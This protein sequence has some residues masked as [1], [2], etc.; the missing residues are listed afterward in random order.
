MKTNDK[1]LEGLK[2][3][4]LQAIEEGKKKKFKESD[5]NR[6]NKGRFAPTNK[7]KGLENLGKALGTDVKVKDYPDTIEKETMSNGKITIAK[8]FRPFYQKAIIGK[9]LHDIKATQISSH[10]YR[11]AAFRDVTP[12]PLGELFDGDVG[13]FAYP[14]RQG[15]EGTTKK[16]KGDNDVGVVMDVDT[17]VIVTILNKD[18]LEES[19]DM[20][21]IFNQKQMNF[22]NEGMGISFPINES[23][24]IDKP[25]AKQI[26]DYAEGVEINEALRTH[27]K[28]DE[29]L[30]DRGELA[31]DIVDLINDARRNT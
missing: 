25:L 26:K 13:S 7:V 4:R 30:S 28:G 29:L 2:E 5:R 14:E 17:G 19:F 24:E 27:K 6:D 18:D 1:I 21:I 8:K 10:A 16:I 12:K 11:R 3:K 20:K 15:E 23:I 22:I 31:C 9:K